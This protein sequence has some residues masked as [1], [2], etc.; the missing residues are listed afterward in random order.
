MIDKLL[1][2]EKLTFV[3]A[4]ADTVTLLCSLQRGEMPRGL[5]YNANYPLVM[6]KVP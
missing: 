5:E 6:L 4:V 2:N 3:V 1:K